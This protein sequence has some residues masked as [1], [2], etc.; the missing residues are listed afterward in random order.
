MKFSLVAILSFVSI[1][2]IKAQTTVKTS[3]LWQVSGNG[4]QKPSYLFGTFHLMCKEDFELTEAI[5][6]AFE[7]TDQLFEEMKMDDPTVQ[8]KM[9]TLMLSKKSLKEQLGDDMYSK[10]DSAFKK[11]TGMPLLLFNNMK[12]FAAFSLLTQKSITCT[13]S[14]MPEMEFIQLAKSVN[15]PVFGLETVEDEM[16]AIDKISIDSQLVFLKQS[17]LNFDSTKIAMKEMQKQY[18][19]RNPEALAKYMKD[20]GASGDFEA[21]LLEERNKAWLPVIEKNMQEKPSF[22]AF[23]AGHL[24]GQIGIITLLK[25]KGYTLTPIAY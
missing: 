21:A 12:P 23:G 18:K 9:M 13:E 15:K 2:F 3:L 19:T 16:K 11:I 14:V 20:N 1:Y 8:M 10:I 25:Q 4:L 17:C 24:G 7:N 22:F 5:K 6:K